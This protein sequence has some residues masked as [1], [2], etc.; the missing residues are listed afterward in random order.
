MPVG[1]TIRGELD[2]LQAETVRAD[3]GR[4]GK[5]IWVT[6]ILLQEAIEARE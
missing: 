6:R 2:D 1:D 4:R 5:K 3:E